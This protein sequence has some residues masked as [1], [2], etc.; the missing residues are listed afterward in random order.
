MSRNHYDFIN[1]LLNFRC[2]I[3]GLL[4]KDTLCRAGDVRKDGGGQLVWT[5]EAGRRT[6]I[7]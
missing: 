2:I 1:E 4:R 5:P 6:G 7:F 3:G